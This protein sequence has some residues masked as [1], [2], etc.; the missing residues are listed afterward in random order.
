MPRRPH[1][2]Q[3]LLELLLDG[4]RRWTE[5]AR[6]GRHDRESLQS[7]Q[8][9]REQ[10]LPA[11][12]FLA[13]GPVLALTAPAAFVA[14]SFSCS[15][16]DLGSLR[17]TQASTG[18]TSASGAQGGDAGASGGLPT[19]GSGQAGM[20]EGGVPEAGG[21]D[22]GAGGEGGA[23]E[24]GCGPIT[25]S[26]WP[27][28]SEFLLAPGS[29]A[30]TRWRYLGH[31]PPDLKTW[32][33]PSFDDST[34]TPGYPGIFQGE[35]LSGDSQRTPWPAGT[36]A[37]WLRTTFRLRKDDIPNVLFWSRWQDGLAVWVNGVPA[38][39]ELAPSTGYRYLGL[40]DAARSALVAGDNTLAARVSVSGLANNNR[41]F[42]LGVTTNIEL[43]RGRPSS[44]FELSKPLEALTS[45]VERYMTEHGIPAGQLAVMKGDS[46]V[47]SRAF[48]WQDATLCLP[49]PENAPFRLGANDHFITVGGVRRLLDEGATDPKTGALLGPS[50]HVFT[51]LESQGLE[52]VPGHAPTTHAAEVTLADLMSARAGLWSLPVAT[53]FY[54]ALGKQPGEEIPEDDVRWLF[55]DAVDRGGVPDGD[56]TSAIVLRYLIRVLRG[57]PLAYLNQLEPEG[58]GK[59]FLRAHARPG[60]RSPLEPWYAAFDEP[61]ARWIS[62]ENADSLAASALS[63]VRYMRAYDLVIG[64]PLF[65]P[66]TQA[67]RGAQGEDARTA[68]MTGSFNWLWQ[69]RTERIGVALSFNIDGDYGELTTQLRELTSTIQD[70]GP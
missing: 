14:L 52:P 12:P 40:S 15:P 34:W 11:T 57:D 33:L 20:T 51:L 65:D 22:G 31:S 50:T 47:L 55:S 9:K 5:G 39:E 35:K 67:W 64:V 19:Q 37:I 38:V 17:D 25:A 70:F 1:H 18:G 10:A 63:L 48:G 49:L 7:E 46:V 29:V 23:P 27:M 54:A 69:N 53:D 45:L 28:P 30:E 2:L 68:R 36:N 66:K 21:A 44:G 62:L 32:M 16:R 43:A 8:T 13:R 4:Y 56:D 26:Y 24:P 41:Y 61:S 58:E 60:D 59:A 3:A 6:R 42:D